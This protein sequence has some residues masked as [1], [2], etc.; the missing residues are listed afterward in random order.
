M[1]RRKISVLIV[2]D[3]AFMRK[4][5][6]RMLA[7]DP[8]IRVVGEAADGG[9]GVAAV[10]RLRPDVV[11]LDIRMRR[12]DGIQA[13]K[14]IMREVPTPVLMVSAV[15]Q[16]GGAE[17]LRALEAGAVDFIDKSS[18]H[19][20]MDILEIADTLVQKVKVLSGVDVQKLGPAR[21]EP[22]P[23]P[24]RT[25]VEAAPEAGAAE[26]V[27]IG[28]T[29]RPM[30]LVVIGSSTGGPM[31]L[32]AIL[33]GLPSSYP[34]AILV[35][36]HM[37]KGFTRSLADRLDSQ[38]A[39]HFKEAEED[40]LIRPGTIFIG[41]SGYHLKLKQDGHQHRVWL[42]RSPRD[43]QHCPSVDVLFQAVAETWSGPTLAIVLTGM[44]TDGSSGV[45]AIKRGG[46]VVLAQ[47]EET[48]VVYGMP[49]AAYNTGC[50]DR[51]LPRG[52]FA[53]AIL[54]FSNQVVRHN[55]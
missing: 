41:P 9:E 24:K 7:S 55:A 20:M 14:Q 4:A 51:M 36:Q 21:P 27:P 3:S 12:M 52:Q 25:P 11:T 43:T 8:E 32:E 35:V 46:G 39:I 30:H 26:A 5:L 31:T 29:D 15:T 37:P 18:C 44:G 40:D 53:R 33:T 50:V 10:K 48:C 42:T 34:G 2:D 28:A 47:S 54:E 16:E 23:T 45:R 1:A 13:L 19:T 6:K 22:A 38:A 49:N 17:T